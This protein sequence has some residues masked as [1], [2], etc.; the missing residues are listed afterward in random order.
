MATHSVD[1]LCNAALY[2]LVQTP[3]RYDPLMTYL[4]DQCHLL[5]QNGTIITQS[6]RTRHF[7]KNRLWTC[8]LCH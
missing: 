5:Y 1:S 7:R 8:F 4:P 3:D 6:A 2:Y